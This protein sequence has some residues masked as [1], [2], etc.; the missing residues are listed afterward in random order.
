MNDYLWEKNGADAEI[1][2]LESLLAVYRYAEAEAP[3]LPATNIIPVTGLSWRRRFSLVFA[4]GTVAA[5]LFVG[6]LYVRTVPVSGPV[7]DEKA[8][9]TNRPAEVAP[10]P[11]REIASLPASLTPA[12]SGSGIKR[13]PANRAAKA[14][15]ATYRVHKR[16][17]NRSLVAKRHVEITS[18]EM[19]AYNQ[20]KLALFITGTKLRSVSDTIG[21]IENRDVSPN[22]R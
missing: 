6:F 19:Y 12:E 5:T 3:E 14:S 18:E 9:S 10:T 8:A 4:F 17:F 13:A 20:V 16:K 2:E 11:T 15:L 7:S 1:E 22:Q 21:K